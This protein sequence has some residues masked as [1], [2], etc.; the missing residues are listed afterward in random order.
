MCVQS[1][2]ILN[3]F[4][5]LF[6][7]LF[8]LLIFLLFH[9]VAM[10]ATAMVAM[11]MFVVVTATFAIVAS[12]SATAFAGKHLQGGG[13]FLLRGFTDVNHLAH[14]DE[15]LASQGM[16]QVHGNLSIANLLN[17]AVEALAVGILQGHYGTFVD[18]LLVQSAVYLECSTW[19]ADDA[20]LFILS[21]GLFGSQFKVELGILLQIYNLCLEVVERHAQS[22]NKLERLFLRCILHEFALAFLILGVQPV[23]YGH[24]LVG[25]NIC[26]NNL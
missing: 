13:D 12:T 9:L 19:H 18:I 22:A 26:H 2:Y 10:S 1:F 6:S 25:F 3:V 20:L 21:V 16:V 8:S 14:E 11:V 4:I 23:G 5:S 15:F 7:F 17:D 24:V